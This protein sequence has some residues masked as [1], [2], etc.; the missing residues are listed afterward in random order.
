MK[1]LLL[2]AVFSAVALAAKDY[3]QMFG[4][5]KATH[6]KSYA[7]AGEEATRFKNFVRNMKKAEAQQAANPL[8]VFGANKFADLSEAEFG[9]YSNGAE[10]FKKALAESTHTVEAPLADVVAAAGEKI[11]W[12]E[13]GAV[14]PVKD[15]GACGSCWAFS[16]I[17]NIEGQAFLGGKPL[18]GLSEQLL[19][20]CDTIDS[21][22]RGGLMDNAF[23][24]LI[25]NR[26]G[27]VVTEAAYPYVSG[28][29][30]NPACKPKAELDAMP[31]GAT[32]KSFNHLAKSEDTLA[33]Y[34]LSTGPIAVAV[35]S[36]SFQSYRSGILT[37]CV[38]RQLTHAVLAVG[39]N[40]E[41]VPPYWIVK[42]SWGTSW[43]EGGYIR[44]AKGTNQCLINGYSTTAILKN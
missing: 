6:L 32:L 8:A 9:A 20:S 5:F 3:E 22:C 41:H 23:N 29:G 16:A 19:N 1:S 12:R 14:T 38:N 35:D 36:T 11:D 27:E 15:Q 24:W 31:V 39:F 34:V 43:G 25:N 7:D 30:S 10:Y 28:S 13:K 2:L 40:D 21:G 18:T 37:N 44:L 42:N 4:E 26:K 33:A 17:G